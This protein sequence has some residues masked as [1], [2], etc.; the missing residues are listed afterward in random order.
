[1]NSVTIQENVSLARFTTLG[2]GGPA[3]YFCVATSEAEIQEGLAFAEGHGLPVFVLGGGSNLL[4]ADAGFPGLVLQAALHGVTFAGEESDGAVRV[5]AGAGEDW[6]AFVGNCVE[7]NLAGVECLS[8]IPGWVGGSPVQ[9][10]GAYGQ[11]VS[12]TIVSV[13]VY[14]R[15]E[16]R[17]VVLPA[18]DCGFAYRTSLF[19]TVA[20]GRYLVLSVTFDLTPGGAPLLRYGDVR[21]YFEERGEASPSLP[22]VREAVRAIRARKSMLLQPDDPDCRSAGSFF[23]NPIV[24]LDVFAA[25]EAAARVAGVLA[26]GE[27]VPHYTDSAGVK[28][29]AA[30]LIERSGFSR[31]YG[32]GRVGLSRKHTLA[33]VNRGDATAGDVL[34]LVDEIRAGVHA[35]FGVTLHPEPVFVGFDRSEDIDAAGSQQSDDS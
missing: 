7:R 23:K 29:P 35:R 31:G 9:N 3:R 14:D 17:S 24:S 12:E 6:D 10:I 4:V 27:S 13:C 32:T 20:R 25:I 11:E 5:T 22:A 18:A 15:R 33:I 2:V 16:R 8:G 19:N 28:V 30:W 26:A 1:M 21:R 34:A